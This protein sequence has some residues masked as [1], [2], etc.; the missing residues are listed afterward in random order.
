MS[1]FYLAWLL[2]A[3]V[4]AKFPSSRATTR[5]A[6]LCRQCLHN[7]W[8]HLPRSVRRAS[9]SR[10]LNLR[11]L[12]VRSVHARAF[13]E[14][15]TVSGARSAKSVTSVTQLHPDAEAIFKDSDLVDFQCLPKR[16]PSRSCGDRREPEATRLARR[17][18]GSGCGGACGRA[19]CV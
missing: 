2:L 5:A 7:W 14:R 8:V 1:A 4:S 9:L 10:G 16:I 19:G 3:K 17:A 15:E 13:Y 18:P 6:G 12:A 11:L